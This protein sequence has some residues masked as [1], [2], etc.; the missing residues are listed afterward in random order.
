MTTL[1]FLKMIIDK[2][3]KLNINANKQNIKFCVNN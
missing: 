1:R 2:K 3:L